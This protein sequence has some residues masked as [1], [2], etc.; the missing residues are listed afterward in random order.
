MRMLTRYVHSAMRR[1]QYEILEDDR[2]YFGRVPDLQGA[3]AKAGTIEE[4][5]AELQEVVEEWIL[6]GLKRN[7]PLPVLDGVAL[8]VTAEA[9]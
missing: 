7:D 1:A 9:A 2:S 8:N 5:R 4:C 6:L 3:W